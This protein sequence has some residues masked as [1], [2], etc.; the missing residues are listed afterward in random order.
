MSQVAILIILV[1]FVLRLMIDFH[2]SVVCLFLGIVCIVFILVFG[3]VY[4]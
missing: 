3:M 4:I 2:S 1:K